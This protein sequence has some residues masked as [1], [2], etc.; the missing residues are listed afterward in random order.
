MER[1]KVGIVEDQQLVRDGLITLIKSTPQLELGHVSHGVEDYL[2]IPLQIPDNVLLLDIG[3]PGGMTGLEGIRPIKTSYPATEIIMLTTFDDSARVFKALCAGASAYLTKRTPFPKITEAITT[4]HRGGSYMSPSIARKVVEYFAP[5][6]KQE[7][8]L[9]PRQTQITD[10]LVEGMS[11]K[12]I[13]D[14]LMISTETVRDHIKKIYKKLQIN[15]RGELISM[16][17][18]GE[19]D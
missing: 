18:R 5:R 3:L 15:S 12:M 11:Y 14:K 10:A 7:S 6:Q 13:A 2:D 8:T 9:T 16:R 4:V 1:I 19:L 17:V